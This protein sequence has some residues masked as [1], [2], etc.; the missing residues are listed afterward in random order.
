MRC[1]T[2]SW[3]SRYAW[4]SSS[5]EETLAVAMLR[6][7]CVT[8]EMVGSSVLGARIRPIIQAFKCLPNAV[9]ARRFRGVC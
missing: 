3:S 2:I 4:V 1:L 7:N 5:T 9:T 6:I 8:H